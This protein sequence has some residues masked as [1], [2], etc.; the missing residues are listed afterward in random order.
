MSSHLEITPEAE[1]DIFTIA[2][3]IRIQDSLE[4][5]MHAVSELKK[6]LNTLAENPESGRVGG[7][8]GT[9]EAIMTGLPY[10]AIYKKNNNSVMVLRVLHGAAERR[11]NK[12][13]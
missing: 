9:R 8:E 1:R 11:S 2:A 4:S 13:Y 5:A 3:N 12:I 6:H 7:C 10:I